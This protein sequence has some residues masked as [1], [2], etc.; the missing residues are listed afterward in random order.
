MEQIYGVDI[1]PLSQPKESFL[2]SLLRT[3]SEDNTKEE[4]QFRRYVEVTKQ[5]PGYE[6]MNTQTLWMCFMMLSQHGAQGE[7]NIDDYQQA[8]ELFD[9]TT[10]IEYMNKLIPA[11]QNTQAQNENLME[12]MKGQLFRYLRRIREAETLEEQ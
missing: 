12:I 10:L 3:A 9:Q 11:K 7:V 6:Y 1:M 2:K 8:I 4:D 5:I